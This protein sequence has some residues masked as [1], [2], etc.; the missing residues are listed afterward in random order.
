MKRR[1][2]IEK[3]LLGGA[4][5][6]IT[7]GQDVTI[8]DLPPNIKFFKKKIFDAIVSLK[9]P[10]KLEYNSFN[11][12]TSFSNELGFDSLDIIELAMTIENRFDFIF[13]D[14]EL[15]KIDTPNDILQAVLKHAP[16]DV[17]GILAFRKVDFKGEPD[18]FVTQNIKIKPLPYKD[19]LSFKVL[20]GSKIF[21]LDDYD[22]VV[23]VINAINKEV[24]IPDMTGNFFS[25]PSK[26]DERILKK[27][28]K[29][30]AVN[31]L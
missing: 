4:A 22:I 11:W 29:I 16:E 21:F 2:F 26:N 9:L 20:K 30:V 5:Y 25:P 23:G 13:P 28:A 19:Y 6:M 17:K 24:L 7:S 14:A 12:N 27:T 31:C 15:E 8:G 18:W 3:S 10:K 1:E